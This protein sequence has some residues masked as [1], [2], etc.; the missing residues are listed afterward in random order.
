[1]RSRI[2]LGGVL[3]TITGVLWAFIAL[4]YS[5]DNNTFARELATAM[6]VSTAGLLIALIAQEKP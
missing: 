6:A 5:T 2:R 1:M 3:T 4:I